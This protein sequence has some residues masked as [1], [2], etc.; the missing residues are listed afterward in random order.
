M[1]SSAPRTARPR[2]DPPGLPGPKPK[3]PPC[4]IQPKRPV[5]RFIPMRVMTAN[6]SR[7]PV[8][9]A[10][11]QLGYAF[12]GRRPPGTRSLP[13]R[14]RL[15][16][17]AALVKSRCVPSA[18]V[19]C[20]MACS[21]ARLT[22]CP[23]PSCRR[24]RPCRRGRHRNAGDS[25][26]RPRGA[27][28]LQQRHRRREGARPVTPELFGRVISRVWSISGLRRHDL[29]PGARSRR[30]RRASAWP[31]DGIRDVERDLGAAGRGAG[32][33]TVL[34]SVPRQVAAAVGILIPSSVAATQ[35]VQLTGI[36]LALSV[37]VP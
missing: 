3:S 36:H 22:P 31:S 28:A 4:V 15:T 21:S 37:D 20:W 27:P 11:S 6:V 34:T 23:C 9:M 10:S 12:H 17:R 13:S 19:I 29:R 18:A 33:G 2:P 14:R 32:S 25:V 30:A 5:P 7:A 26:A 35:S 8:S 1:D 24:R 16:C